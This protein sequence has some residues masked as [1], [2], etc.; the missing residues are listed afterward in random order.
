MDMIVIPKPRKDKQLVGVVRIR[1]EAE[2]LVRQICI[3]EDLPASE[4]VSRI[5]VAAAPYI[6]FTS[7]EEEK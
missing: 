7:E 1:P 2:E 6:R 3:E 4:V 5:I